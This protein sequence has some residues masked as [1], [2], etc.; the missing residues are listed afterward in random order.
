MKNKK[1]IIPGV[2]ILIGWIL[3][4]LWADKYTYLSK[5]ISIF[6]YDILPY[7]TKID[8]DHNLIQ[9]YAFV[10]RRGEGWQDGYGLET[11][12]YFQKMDSVPTV[13]YDTIEQTKE[14]LFIY[15]IDQ[16]GY[17]DS[18]MIIKVTDLDKKQ[19]YIS[20]KK[21][22]KPIQHT[23]QYN[24]RE[25]TIYASKYISIFAEDNDHNDY[26]WVNLWGTKEHIA[27]LI[28]FFSFLLFPIYIIVFCVL[29]AKIENSDGQ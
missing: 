1:I 13:V 27:M 7:N 20:P 21:L 26:T 10:P 18:N 2:L 28:C 22:D 14:V 15:R 17:N 23:V 8:R 3:V 29:V 12:L 6:S 25:W 16:Y 4:F 5:G 24:G 9:F 19:Y 11:Q